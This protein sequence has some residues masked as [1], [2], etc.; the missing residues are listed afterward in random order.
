MITILLDETVCRLDKKIYRVGVCCVEIDEGDLGDVEDAIEKLYGNIKRDSVRFPDIQK[1]H[2]SDFNH[3]QNS[4]IIE[5]LAKLPIKVKMYTYYLFGHNEAEV[6]L[7]AMQN[8]VDNIKNYQHKNRE[9]NIQIEFATEYKKTS[10]QGC[11]TKSQLTILPDAILYVYNNYLNI[12]KNQKKESNEPHAILYKLLR[13]KIRLQV[14]KAKNDDEYLQK[15]ER[16]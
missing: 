14:F 2:A 5:I 7:R 1:V 4:Y 3:S 9:I 16:L 10:L 8:T 6:K 11:L 15:G 13:N 12:T